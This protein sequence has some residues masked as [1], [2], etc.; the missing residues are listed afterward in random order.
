M[1]IFFVAGFLLFLEGKRGTGRAASRGGFWMRPDDRRTPERSSFGKGRLFLAAIL[2]VASLATFYG[3][4]D[5]TP[6]GEAPSVELSPRQEIALGLQ[7]APEMA[8]R[9]GGLHPN[10]R[11]QERVDEICTAIVTKTEAGE[12]PYEFECHVLADE[13]RAD[14]FAL[15]GGQ[16]FLTAGLLGRL[17]TEGQ[18]A[19]VLGHEIAHV[20][21]RHGVEH[22]ATVRLSEGSAGAAV[23]AAYDP[24]D[25]SS[26]DSPAM[27]A[28]IGHMPG[29]RFS[30]EEELEADRLG[31]RLLADAGFGS[32]LDPSAPSLTHHPGLKTEPLRRPKSDPRP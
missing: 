10:Q 28:L 8:R 3:S 19:G 13:G 5:E 15:P 14:A 12:T 29:L 23:L 21:A 26:R 17:E 30:P 16:V 27:A 32:L 31:A 9:Y 2:A 18:L 20:M 22:L 6:A 1:T 25:P 11:E 7:A 24:D 4:R